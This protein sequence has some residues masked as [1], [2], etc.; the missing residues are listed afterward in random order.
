MKITTATGILFQRGEKKMDFLLSTKFKNDGMTKS[1]FQQDQHANESNSRIRH[2][3]FN[4]SNRNK[5]IDYEVSSASL[6]LF[7]T[8]FTHA[9]SD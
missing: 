1:Y 9:Y 7:Q 8:T 5:K 3:E 6:K 2:T 4:H